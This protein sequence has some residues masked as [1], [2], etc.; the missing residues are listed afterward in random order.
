M[1]R[2]SIK[3]S[4]QTASRGDSLIVSGTGFDPQGSFVLTLAQPGV[5][6]PLQ[7]PVRVAAGGSFS[8][9]VFIPGQAT[10]GPATLSACAIAA[11]GR[12]EGC[13][14]LEISVS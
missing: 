13:T 3:S 10:P 8:I 14:Q 7:P 9:S 11:D 5:A 6:Y 2:L 4:T 1:S 12:S